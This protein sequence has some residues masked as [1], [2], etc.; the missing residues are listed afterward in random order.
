MRPPLVWLTLLLIGCGAL[1]VPGDAP[2]HDDPP[3]PTDLDAESLFGGLELDAPAVP[4]PRQ[5][6]PPT[7]LRPCCAFGADLKVRVGPVPIPLSIG[8]VVDVDSLGRHRYDG[9][10]VTVG[11]DVR[12]GFVATENNGM[13]Y[14]C[15]SGFIDMAHVRDYADWTVYLSRAL[16]PLV[17]TGGVLELPEE[18]GHRLV[19]V[20]AVDGETLDALGAGPLALEI[21]AWL[22]FQLSIWHEIATWY[23]WSAL[24]GFPETVSA[25][26]PE[27]LYSNLAGILMARAV[28][29][30]HPELSLEGFN[31]AMDQAIHQG[32]HR[33]GALP[34]P[35]SRACAE[36]VD[37]AWWD[38]AY[39]LPA[40]DLVRRR[41]LDVGRELTPWLATPYFDADLSAEIRRR[42][43]TAN[44]T[45]LA[46]PVPE[47][48]GDVAI[49]DLA[50]LDLRVT[51]GIASDFPF[52][53][54]P[55]RWV[56]QD[57]FPAILSAVR[58]QVRT[59]F[60]DWG[61]HP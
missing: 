24:A 21:A 33:V 46:L 15:R 47:R 16:E 58:H 59:R 45:P 30:D 35:L 53:D 3:P 9:G 31:D 32:L 52:P 25:F 12:A 27:D 34:E 1:G 44:P 55:R 54:A 60:G 6:A 18:A 17:E 50:R 13:I 22:A 48:V 49:R 2:T 29:R 11:N 42:C 51:P 5:F 28:L 56:D 39:R 40:F 37:G 14:T 36:A 57:D 38:S 20:T 23:G 26:S 10:L 4:G 7:S 43:G 19:Y 8:N 41:N 61:D